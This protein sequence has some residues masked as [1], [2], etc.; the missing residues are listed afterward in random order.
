MNLDSQF[1]TLMHMRVLTLRETLPH[2]PD[3]IYFHILSMF[4][5]EY[6]D[7]TA[8][9]ANECQF[10]TEYLEKCKEYDVPYLNDGGKRVW[11]NRSN[12]LPHYIDDVSYKWRK[13]DKNYEYVPSARILFITGEIVE[14]ETDI[15]MPKF[16]VNF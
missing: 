16:E 9:I 4:E 6:K 11:H 3:D 1:M 8:K 7:E 2:I 13:N 10:G 12:G 14:M 5:R 15:D